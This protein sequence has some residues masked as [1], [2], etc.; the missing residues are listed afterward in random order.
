MGEAA[1][2]HWLAAVAP[3]LGLRP[4]AVTDH[5]GDGSPVDAWSAAAAAAGMTDEDLARAVAAH[6]RLGVADL[7]AAE[8][9]ALKLV[10][11]AVARRYDVF[12]LRETDRHLVVATSDPTNLELE[13]VI[14]FASGR[15]TV[16]EIAPPAVIARSIEEH[17]SPDRMLET[18]LQA[19]DHDEVERV[20]IVDESAA[21]AAT[22]GDAHAA[23][24]VKLTNLVLR[25]AVEQGASDIHIE[26]GRRGGLVRFRVDG[27]MRE[28]M[29]LP[30]AA[31]NR[32]VSRVK[33]LGGLDIADRLRPQDGRARIRV[34]DRLFDLRISTVPTRDS[35]KA[36][37]RVLDP[38]SSLG[39]DDLE[40]PGEELRRLRRLLGFRDGIVLVTG[41]TGSGKTTTLYAALRE[42]ATGEVNIM[43]VEDPV[44][45]ELA[46]ITQIQVEPKRG[47]TFASALRAILRQDPDVILVGEIRDLETAEVAVQ[48]A[49]T[50]HLVLATLHA[51]DAAGAVTRLLDLGLDR[52]VV[53]DALRGA[54]SQRLAR[55]L[56]G[57]CAVPAGQEPL[58][59][60]ERELAARYG[61]TPEVRAVGCPRCLGTGYR[62]RIAV[63]EV[64]AVTD[65]L[66][67]LIARGAP[68]GELLRAAVVA[69]MRPMRDVALERVRRGVTTLREIDRVLGD[70][71]EAPAE[72]ADAP[73]VL[74]VDD[75]GVVRSLARALLEKNGCRVSEAP[76]GAAGLERLTGPERYDLMVLD[77]DMP[78]LNGRDVLARVRGDVTTAAL[79]VIVLT[80]SYHEN[81]EVTLM[82]EGADDYIRKPLEPARFLARVKGA[83]RR[84]SSS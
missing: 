40:L 16:F 60:D 23:P 6:F 25:S 58:S 62:G 15:R 68:T 71:G 52:T 18:L 33:I 27:V 37:I 28:Y 30:M 59:D 42:L 61:L 80:G 13:Q 32:V 63:L 74:L 46:G 83:L 43:T 81:L 50:G 45:Y 70:A 8:P 69:G 26:P 73:H 12:P 14:G 22:A 72:P 36:V 1:Q 54:L 75:D 20:R 78:R 47:V 82:E 56:C 31:H 51:N 79:P 48:A 55:R 64:A 34:A 57:D 39:L 2:M 66:R 84:A 38:E 7:T 44:E 29:P 24:V 10:P 9:R 21:D 65:A 49:L 11:E 19:V 77:L 53:A 3:Q 35:E 67:G 17:Y 76:D 41:P 5:A 4:D